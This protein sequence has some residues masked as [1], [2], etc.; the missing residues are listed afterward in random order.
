[1]SIICVSILHKEIL[2]LMFFIGRSQEIENR[3]E[4]KNRIKKQM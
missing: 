2:S 3:N 4:Y 1:M